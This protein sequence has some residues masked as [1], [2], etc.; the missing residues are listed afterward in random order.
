MAALLGS[1]ESVRRITGLS[2]GNVAKGWQMKSVS[3]V[4]AGLNRMDTNAGTKPFALT[5]I[6]YSAS[7]VNN[8][9]EQNQ[10]DFVKTAFETLEQYRKQNRVE[11]I[12]WANYADYAPEVYQP[13][14]SQQGISGSAEFCAFMGNLGLRTNADNFFYLSGTLQS[15]RCIELFCH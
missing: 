13:Y 2:G 11:F 3:Q 5:E 12:N 4:S 7:P 10:T 1:H 15:R 9:S 8:S 14:A 6:G